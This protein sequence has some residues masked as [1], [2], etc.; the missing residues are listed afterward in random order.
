MAIDHPNDEF[1]FIF[2]RRLAGSFF[3]PKIFTLLCLV[4]LHDIL[5]FGISGLSFP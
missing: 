2:D 4:R 5:F 3:L 1:F